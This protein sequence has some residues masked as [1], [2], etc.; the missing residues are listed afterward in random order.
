[1]LSSG[2]DL[3][4]LCR[5]AGTQAILRGIASGTPAADMRITQDDLQAAFEAWR[6]EACPRREHGGVNG[7]RCQSECP[8]CHKA[9]ELAF[10]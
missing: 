10:R 6:A 9:Q 7:I 1:M 3:A 4:G 2:A 8:G 5:E